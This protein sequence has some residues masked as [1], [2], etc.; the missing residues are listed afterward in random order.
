MKENESRFRY[1]EIFHQKN[2]NEIIKI[3]RSGEDRF[4]IKKEMPIG[5]VW[6]GDHESSVFY[7]YLAS[8]KSEIIKGDELEIMNKTFQDKIENHIGSKIE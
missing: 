3:N 4:L 6:R 2:E 1:S 8:Q 5:L 7:A